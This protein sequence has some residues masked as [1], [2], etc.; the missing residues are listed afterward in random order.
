MT[1]RG[2]STG[3]AG[4]GTRAAR[5][6]WRSPCA[7]PRGEGADEAAAAFAAPFWREFDE[8]GASLEAATG[9]PASAGVVGRLLRAALTLELARARAPLERG[10]LAGL[11]T[12]LGGPAEDDP[13]DDDD[14]P[15]PPS[16]PRP[17]DPL[18][19]WRLSWRAKAADGPERAAL[20][21]AALEA[22]DAIALEPVDVGNDLGP[23]TAIARLLD[24]ARTRRAL[25]ICDKMARA[26]WGHELSA[27]RAYLCGR[28]AALGHV[29]EAEALAARID[30]GAHRGY[31]RGLAFGLRAAREGRW[32]L[33]GVVLTADEARGWF[34]GLVDGREGPAAPPPASFVRAC[35]ARAAALPDGAARA[36]ALLPLGHAWCELGPADEWLAAIGA[37]D[38]ERA[39]VHLWLGLGARRAGE[40]AAA[41]AAAL[42]VEALASGRHGSPGDWLDDACAMRASLPRA[43][44]AAFFVSVARQAALG[45]GASLLGGLERVDDLTGLLRWLG[46]DGAEVETL[47]AL[48]EV[49]AL[50]ARGG[51]ARSQPPPAVE[52]P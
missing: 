50:L 19:A 18:R 45:R 16:L 17:D 31:A 3:G 29:G 51:G 21:D 44:F 13:G 6:R 26:D 24:E 40:P 15:G 20:L 30:D 12:K 25:A 5:E 4:D 14:A 37:C 35:V 2:D 33:E 52:C 7:A 42:A 43:D 10:R 39:R 49:E 8:A 1:S 27:A 23:F 32:S 11:R 28:L 41:R 38:E 36:A 22:F 34:Q 46:G 48:D 47:R 9:G